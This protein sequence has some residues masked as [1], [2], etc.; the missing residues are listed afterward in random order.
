MRARCLHATV[1]CHQNYRLRPI[2][3]PPVVP[4]APQPD[5]MSIFV[6]LQWQRGLSGTLVLWVLGGDGE[7]AGEVKSAVTVARSSRFAG[8]G[9]IYRDLEPKWAIQRSMA[10]V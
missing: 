6:P 2:Q 9:Q 10:K 5:V 7:I 4:T 1:S 8:R 3:A